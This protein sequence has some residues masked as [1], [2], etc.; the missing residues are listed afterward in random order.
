MR[1]LGISCLSHDA[2]IAL[3]NDGVPEIVIEEER[4]NREKRTLDFPAQALFEAFDQRGLT[5]EDVDAITTP[6]CIYDMRIQ[7]RWMLLRGFPMSL[8]LLRKNALGVIPRYFIFLDWVLRS[9]LRKHFKNARVPKIIQTGHHNAH[10]ASY[11]VSPFDEATV[12][13]MDGYG[14]NCSTSVYQGAGDRLRFVRKNQLTD[15]LGIFYTFISHYLGF[16]N[17]GDEGKVMGLAAYGEPTYVERFRDLVLLGEDGEY[18]LN[19]EYFCHHIYGQNRPFTRKFLD[20]FGP[21]TAFGSELT[22]RHKDL[23]FALQAVTEETIL[24]IVRALH[25]QYDVKKLCLVGGVAMNCV[26]NS[27]ILEHT[28][29]EEIW[30]P[31]CASDTGVP[32]GSALWHHHQTLKNPRSLKLTHPFYGIGYTDDEIVA[33]L[34]AAGL[35]YERLEVPEL[36]AAVAD[37]LADGKIIGWFQDKFEMGARALGNRSIL[38]DPRRA[39]MKDIINARIKHREPFRPFAPAVLIEHASEYFEIDQADPYMT[40]APRVRKAKQKLIPAAVHVDGTGRFQTVER[41]AN[42]RYY[43]VIEAFKERTGIPVL[44]NT[45]FNRQEPIVARPE[46]AI[47]C[48]LRTDMD[49]LVL[50]NFYSTDRNED[51]IKRAHDSFENPDKS[52]A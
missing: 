29:V 32:L 36:L 35:T 12:L 27:K 30:V 17:F 50:G 1:I 28:D 13:V 42:P 8:N 52:S 20:A 10:A 15:S 47:S 6:W 51:A 14:D 37:D 25:K 45:S 9:G 5:L 23:A 41:T 31:P 11:Y 40:I 24:H 48:Y 46:E 3:I 21:P 43:G 38:A 26:A 2:G 33:A 4:L 16:A 44:L 49:G 19:R 7:I 22:Q 39:E 34:K 18:A